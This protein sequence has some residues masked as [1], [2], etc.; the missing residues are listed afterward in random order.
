MAILFGT[1]ANLVKNS[2][3]VRVDT[4]ARKSTTP[5]EKDV[6][7]PFSPSP[8]AVASQPLMPGTAKKRPCIRAY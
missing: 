1:K 5:A 7:R 2:T 6:C 3:A 4:S 8:L